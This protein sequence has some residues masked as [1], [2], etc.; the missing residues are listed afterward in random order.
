MLGL[1][2]FFS[3]S[4]FLFFLF[5]LTAPLV[6]LANAASSGQ[7]Q[8]GAE[9]P[10]T[11]FSS[12]IPLV[13]SA[14]VNR[15]FVLAI[16]KSKDLLKSCLPSSFSGKSDP[17][18]E[19]RLQECFCSRADTLFSVDLERRKAIAVFLRSRPDLKGKAFFVKGPSGAGE[20][21]VSLEDQS[22]RP[23]LDAFLRENGCR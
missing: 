12:A 10:A 20:W 1:P 18:T 23:S 17:A 22:E 16:Q 9:A 7:F 4:F 11:S 2:R 5:A 21:M 8:Q 13:D 14:E 6:P 3:K 15:A 19:R